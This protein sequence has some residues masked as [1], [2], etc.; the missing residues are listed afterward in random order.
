MPLAY[1]ALG[2]NQPS[3]AGPPEATLVAAAARLTSLGNLTACS[4]LYSTAPVGL[5]HEIVDQ[6]RF[7]NAVVALETNLAPDQL[8]HA[9]LAMEREFGRNR[10]AGTANGPRTLDLDILLYGDLILREFDLEIPHPRFAE[11]AFVLIP[12]SEIAPELHDPRSGNTV[13]QLLE[14]LFPPPETAMDAAIK[15]QSD[16]WRATVCPGSGAPHAARPGAA[17]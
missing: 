4:S 8:L 9:L 12:L 13:S 2:A 17:E 5:P 11:R 1:I 10:S 6:P 16:H 15:I 14:S 7:L 3:P